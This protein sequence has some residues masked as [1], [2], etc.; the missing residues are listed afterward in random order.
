MKYIYIPTIESVTSSE[1]CMLLNF[2]RILISIFSIFSIFL[3]G[4]GIKLND[5]FF[6][7]IASLLLISVML[8]YIEFRSKKSDPFN[9]F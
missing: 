3:I 6:F 4:L 9:L 7:I 5:T 8:I 1:I 2:Y